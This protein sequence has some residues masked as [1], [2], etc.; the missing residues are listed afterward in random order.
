MEGIIY[1]ISE[2]GL[3]H[4]AESLIKKYDI[5]GPV[6]TH[7][8]A[9]FSKYNFRKI[10]PGNKIELHY[11]VTVV[12]P[13]K[14]LFPARE[15]VICFK[16]NK[17]FSTKKEEQKPRIIFG[18]NL[19]DLESIDR[20]DKEFSDPI[21][22]E[23]Y[24]KN[25]ENTYLF[26]IDHFDP[27]PETTYD[28]HLKKIG[29]KYEVTAG[30]TM[31]REIVSENHLFKEKKSGTITTLEVHDSPIHNLDLYK[32]IE[33]SKDD[34]IWDKLAETCLG[35]G[36]CTYVCPVCYCFE[37][38]DKVTLKGMTKCEGCRERR[39]DSCMLGDFASISS[40]DFRPEIRD[41]IYNWYHHKFV[42]TPKE[43]GFVGCVDCGRCI[44][45]CPARINFH[46]TLT[47]LIKKYS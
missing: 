17:E 23:V 11:G 46:E 19:A 5:Y 30:S 8:E 7:D 1:T 45:Y 4:L 10:E 37:T 40:H 3:R 21:Q 33:K 14:Y 20:L 38:E 36:I 22:D 43:H 24:T 31:G 26:S 27:E 29:E 35:C 34:P 12:P 15:K 32:I 25:R 41:R 42:R 44:V 39:W 9:V 28:L 2:N 6:N 18:L 16:N 13:A 47:Y